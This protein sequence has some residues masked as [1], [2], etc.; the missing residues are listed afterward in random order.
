M[1]LAFVNQQS[2]VTSNIIG[3]TNL[4]QL[5]ENIHSINVHLSEEI[6]KDIQAV[7]EKMPNPAP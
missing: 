2:F 5:E 4:Q 6:L 1:S 7:H 3:A